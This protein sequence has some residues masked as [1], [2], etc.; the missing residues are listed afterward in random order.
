M[1]KATFTAAAICLLAFA[2]APAAADGDRALV[3]GFSFVDFL[4]ATPAE[5]AAH[6]RLPSLP[7]GV[8]NFNG[9]PFRIGSPIAVTGIDS[10]RA[11]EFFPTEAEIVI[12]AKARRIHL[13][14]TALFADKDGTPLAKIIL[15]YANGSEEAL[16]MGYGIHV[17]DWSTPRLEKSSELLDPN[18]QLA[19]TEPDDRGSVSR[20]FQT[21]LENPRPGESI[22]RI[23]VVSL[24]SRATPVLLA[25]SLEQETATRPASLPLPSRKAIR[26]LK[27]FPDVAYR[28]EIVARVKDAETGVPLSNAVV[29]LTITDDKQTYFLGEA[30][31]SAEGSCRLSY[32]PQYAV[33]IT[34]WAHAP[35]R[36]PELISESK[37]NQNLFKAEYTIAL[38]RGATVGGLVRD[39]KGK[40][41]AGAEV[42]IHHIT[43]TGTRHYTRVDYDS[44][45]TDGDGR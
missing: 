11:G 14:H 31:S 34:L 41:V 9:I 42:V 5:A 28:R 39:S 37:T 23:K 33:G 29:S 21:A 44:V 17:R 24:F 27:E 8:R 19:W 18:S 15:R 30:K 6:R 3:D 4:P 10:A 25:L 13:L 36:I 22:A 16:R 20:V 26:A 40:P 2:Q 35:G 43:K 32:S 1:I 7:A 45:R 12:G 38:R